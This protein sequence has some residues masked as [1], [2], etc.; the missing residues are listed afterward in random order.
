LAEKYVGG[1]LSNITKQIIPKSEQKRIEP[2]NKK[3]NTNNKS[4]HENKLSKFDTRSNVPK[5][6]NKITSLGNNISR[7]NK[8][9]ITR[10]E[11]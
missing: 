8:N 3:I 10:L 4:G 5:Q 2:V 11:K 7:K 6:S 9:L 1:E